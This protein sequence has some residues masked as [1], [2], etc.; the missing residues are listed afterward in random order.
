[1]KIICERG[2]EY[3]TKDYGTLTYDTCPTCAAISAD[4]RIENHAYIVRELTKAIEEPQAC[5]IYLLDVLECIVD[6]EARISYSMPYL[7]DTRLAIRAAIE[8]RNNV[9]QIKRAINTFIQ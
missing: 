2:H 1:M 8:E 6:W 5:I 3:H 4:L 9:E 7:V